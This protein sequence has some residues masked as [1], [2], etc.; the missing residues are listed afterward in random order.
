[1][2]FKPEVNKEQVKK[3]RLAYYLSQGYKLLVLALTIK[4][5]EEESTP[6]PVTL[7]PLLLPFREAKGLNIKI[8]FFFRG[9]M[10]KAKGKDFKTNRS[11]SIKDVLI[12]SSLQKRRA[13]KASKKFPRKKL[14]IRPIEPLGSSR[15]NKKKGKVAIITKTNRGV[16]I[17]KRLKWKIKCSCYSKALVKLIKALNSKKELEGGISLI[18]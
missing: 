1:M 2:L 13:K 18:L 12:T 4:N 15:A 3:Q 8:S 10:L 5:K 11:T 16:I 14:K 6:E 17:R 7:A 9:K